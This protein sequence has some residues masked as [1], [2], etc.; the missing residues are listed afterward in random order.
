MNKTI[1]V[2]EFL[3]LFCALLV[4]SCTHSVT[5][6]SEPEMRDQWAT[7]IRNLETGKDSLLMLGTT[8]FGVVSVEGDNYKLLLLDG[9]KG[10]IVDKNGL[11]VKELNRFY[12]CE[13]SPNRQMYA[14]VLDD[15]LYVNDLESNTEIVHFKDNEHKYLYPAFSPDNSK[16]AFV[17]INTETYEHFLT[18]YSFVNKRIKRDSFVGPIVNPFYNKPND[19]F[20]FQHLYVHGN[21]PDSIQLCRINTETEHV[22]VIYSEP[23]FFTELFNEQYICMEIMSESSQ[24]SN[25]I[26]F[27]WVNHNIINHICLY[28]CDLQTLS[29]FKIAEYSTNFMWTKPA[30]LPDHHLIF[31]GGIL[32]DTESYN[33][34]KIF[35]S[36]ELT[37]YRACFFIYNNA[38]YLAYNKVIKVPVTN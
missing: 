2:L 36:E 11:I 23:A 15:G 24:N 3:F 34:E 6:T 28:K 20:F 33:R 17:S 26:Y 19:L 29:V 1:K 5:K 18:E 22:K 31:F 12:D 8:P 35:H 38:R 9:S 7:L 4:I 16:I 10:I 37:H 32:L 30:N 21:E 27:H 13:L 25:T 14:Y